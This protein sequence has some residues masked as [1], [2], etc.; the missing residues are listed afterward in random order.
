MSV[1]LLLVIVGSGLFVKVHFLSVAF[2]TAL[3]V[4]A[5]ST[6]DVAQINSV[7]SMA[8]TSLISAFWLVLSALFFRHMVKKAI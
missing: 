8:Q 7:A 3:I 1:M 4:N 5:A 2:P 6:M